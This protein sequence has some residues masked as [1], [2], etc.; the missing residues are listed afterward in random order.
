[1]SAPDAPPDNTL[2]VES[3]REQ[4]Q[5]E[6]QARQ[7]TLDAQ[8]R[9][10]LAALRSGAGTSARGSASR[11]FEDQGLDPTQYQGSI[12]DRINEIL[13]SIAP[14]DPNPGSYFKNVGQ[15]V[16]NTDETQYRNKNERTLSN[17]FPTNFETGKISDSLDDPILAGI[18]GEQRG[19]ADNIVNNMLKRG[20][21]TDA[22]KSAAS[23]DLDRQS[24]SVQDR[25]RELG[26]STLA[27][28]RQ[29]LTDV[30]NRGRQAASTLNLGQ[31]FDPYS[32][33]SDVDKAFNDFIGNLSGSIR[34]KVPG[35]LFNTSS[36]AAIAGAGQG[37]QNTAFNPAALAGIIAGQ[38]VN[39]DDPN[40]PLPT[41]ENIF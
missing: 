14:D 8:H 13:G 25:L 32:Y 6:A 7:D 20:V 2:A 19:S 39:P 29:G 26:A 37:A 40:K 5:R 30:A 33:S 36:L 28:G 24:F 10:E 23:A 17:L 21:I 41:G 3:M 34:A 4:Q 1:M 15:D 38:P 9:T 35:S 16:Y 27:S 12:D 22:G 11:Y 31:S 18:L